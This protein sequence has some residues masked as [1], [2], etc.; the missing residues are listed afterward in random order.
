MLKPRCADDYFRY[1]KVQTR[2][3]SLE[4]QITSLERYSRLCHGWVP[5]RNIP[6]QLSGTVPLLPGANPE[7]EQHEPPTLQKFEMHD[8]LR[9]SALTDDEPT[10][11]EPLPPDRLPSPTGAP[12]TGPVLR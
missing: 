12:T 2:K 8:T 11:D 7:S 3:C 10:L 4:L 5:L 9:L 1:S 6:R